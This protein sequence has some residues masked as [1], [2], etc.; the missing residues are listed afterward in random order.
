MDGK[1]MKTNPKTRR[2]LVPDIAWIEIPAGPFISGEGDKPT[3]LNLDAYWM[4]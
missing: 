2:L 4:A 3:P 1:R